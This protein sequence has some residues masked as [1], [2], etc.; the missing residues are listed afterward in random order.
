MNEDDDE[1]FVVVLYSEQ[2]T[3]QTLNHEITFS[4]QQQLLEFQNQVTKNLFIWDE[5][6]EEKQFKIDFQ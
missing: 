4:P 5:I 6:V 2:M 3:F 1:V